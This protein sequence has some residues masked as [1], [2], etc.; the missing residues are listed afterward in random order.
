MKKIYL[1]LCTAAILQTVQA[2]NFTTKAEVLRKLRAANDYFMKKWP[3]PSTRI[4]T[5]KERPANIWTRGVYYEGLL[6][7]YAIDKQKQYYDY[8]VD[9]GERHAWKPVRG[10]VYT[11]HADN[12]NC[13]MT[14][15]DLYRIDPKPERIAA[16]KMNIDSI[17][18][19]GRAND[20]TWIDAIQ[21]AMPIF[22]KLGVTL[23]DT[24]YFDYMYKMYQHSKYLEGGHGL[25][26][27]KDRLWWRD[28]D[29][30][31]PYKEPNGEDCYWSR[32][33]GWVLAALA[34][35]LQELPTSDP[36]YTEYLQDFKSLATALLPLQ[37][38][39]GFWNVSLRD[40]NHYGG[41]ESSGTALF[42]YGMAWGVNNGLLDKKMFLPSIE[43]GWLALAN[44]T[45]QPTGFLSYVQ[46]TGKE[47]K[48]GQPVTVDK[49]PDFEDYGLG[50]VL[51][52]GTE[53]YKLVQ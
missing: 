46:S 5:N 48:D 40:P 23:Q 1:L 25:Y 7:F 35:I 47:P 4:V 27:P 33:N 2:Q 8:A 44:E 11:R 19:T 38:A 37:R 12:Q 18:R 16:I 15:I 17:V 34:L 6:A 51:F 50:C 14:Y 13:G 49:M 43:K 26:N 53:V 3:D 29:F 32:G 21:M 24:T 9:W 20:W 39:D 36:H 28:K 41:K 45:I 52:A 22:V 30:I 42:V 10:E 31:P